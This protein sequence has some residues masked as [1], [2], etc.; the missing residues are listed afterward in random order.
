MA[1]HILRIILHFLRGQVNKL[2]YSLE[3]DIIPVGESYDGAD[4]RKILQMLEN[5]G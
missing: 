2:R 5:I 3:E 1:C 4:R